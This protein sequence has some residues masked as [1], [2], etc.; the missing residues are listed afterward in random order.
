MELK[1][2]EAW[3]NGQM[4]SHRRHWI[5]RKQ[6]SPKSSRFPLQLISAIMPVIKYVSLFAFITNDYLTCPKAHI[7]W[8]LRFDLIQLLIKALKSSEK[9]AVWEKIRLKRFVLRLP[10]LHL[11]NL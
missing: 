6:R 8:D 4:T 7:Y 11:Y 9:E 1:V 2:M 3:Q 5:S 10:V